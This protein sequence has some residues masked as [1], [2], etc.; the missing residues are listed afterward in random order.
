MWHWPNFT[1]K[2]ISCPCCGEVYIDEVS[3]DCLQALRISI[4][5]PLI[6]TSAH[7]CPLHNIKV[8]G[9]PMSEHKKLAFDIALGSHN[10]FQLRAKAEIVGFRGFGLGQTFLHLDCRSKRTIWD[11]GSASR[12]LWNE[13]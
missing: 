8:G 12:K 5:A 3:M 4:G 1:V 2:E 6:L 13:G 11:Y 7:R 10:R 9:A